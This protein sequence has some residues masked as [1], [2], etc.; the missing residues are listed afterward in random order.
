MFLIIAYD[1]SD[2]KRRRKIEKEI[3]SYG[4]RVNYSVFELCISKAELLLLEDMLLGIIEHKEDSIR[5]YPIDKASILKAK[6]LG[7][8]GEP[9]TLESGYVS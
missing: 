2:D 8:R 3:V 6:E 4:I 1:I 7:D 5:L 9:F